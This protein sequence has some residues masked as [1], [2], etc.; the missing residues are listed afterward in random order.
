MDLFKSIFS[1]TIPDAWIND[2]KIQGLFS[3][4]EKCTDSVSDDDLLAEIFHSTTS[5]QLALPE[6]F[7]ENF[8]DFWPT[9]E[10]S[11]QACVKCKLWDF[12]A[13]DVLTASLVFFRHQLPTEPL[14]LSSLCS[15]YSEADYANFNRNMAYI[16]ISLY[17]LLG[18]TQVA[19]GK[20]YRIETHYPNLVAALIQFAK[21]STLSNRPK[22][23]DS[24]TMNMRSFISCLNTIQSA[25]DDPKKNHYSHPQ[26][27]IFFVERIFSLGIRTL[28]Y[29]DFVVQELPRKIVDSF[30]QMPNALMR[31]SLIQGLLIGYYNDSIDMET[32]IT[33]LVLVGGYVFP[34]CH[35]MFC[36]MMMSKYQEDVPTIIAAIEKMDTYQATLDSPLFN[37]QEKNSVLRPARTEKD[38]Y[39]KWFSHWN[40][41]WHQGVDQVF[42]ALLGD[43][44]NYTTNFDSLLLDSIIFDPALIAQYR[45]NYF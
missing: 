40:P 34:V 23:K 9:L 3:L 39:P 2:Q 17:S 6:K 27:E 42:Q 28:L 32:L 12:V 10:H 44:G 19:E 1:P 20:R 25:K 29:N 15:V 5:M 36:K 14:S 35:W 26:E 11:P 37:V 4:I 22:T 7:L 24:Y 16:P 21:G 45:A 33:T 30:R 31:Y 13:P 8:V 41:D 18:I 38:L 43:T